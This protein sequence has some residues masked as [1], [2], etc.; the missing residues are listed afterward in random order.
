MIETQ[1]L[2]DSFRRLYGRDARLFAAKVQ[3]L[4]VRSQLE[5]AILFGEAR[6]ALA[7]NADAHTAEAAAL[8]L[9]PSIES[10]VEIYYAIACPSPECARTALFLLACG[11]PPI[12]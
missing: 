6:E 5:N 12:A 3:D 1:P 10:A 8:K 7:H 4:N 2:L 11:R 9:S